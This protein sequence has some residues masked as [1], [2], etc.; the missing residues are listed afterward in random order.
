MTK[1]KTTKSGRRL[2]DA[3][4]WKPYMLG[5]AIFIALAMT[6][7]AAYWWGSRPQV[8]PLSEPDAS[9]HSPES[10]GTE[11]ETEMESESRS[12]SVPGSVRQEIE[13]RILNMEAQP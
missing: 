12:G 7:Y 13:S 3:D 5:I 9:L 11:P 8:H 2:H 4:I 1:E 6:A 10:P